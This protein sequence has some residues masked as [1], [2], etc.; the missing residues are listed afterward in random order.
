MVVANDDSRSEKR[1]S[2]DTESVQDMSRVLAPQFNL[3]KFS[4]WLS[5]NLK[6]IHKKGE[7]KFKLPAVSA[8]K[9]L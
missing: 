6:L 4:E 5:K 7:T 1:R 2:L 3:E 8:K 9:S